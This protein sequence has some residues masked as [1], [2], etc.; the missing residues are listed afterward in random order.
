MHHYVGNIIEVEGLEIVLFLLSMV[1]CS[2][3]MYVCIYEVHVC[4]YVA[5]ILLYNNNFDPLVGK[6]VFSAAKAAE[7]TLISCRR[8]V[9]K[10]KMHSCI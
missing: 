3:G 4:R 5:V 9:N 1:I 6:R 10:L 7:N 2:I 8:T